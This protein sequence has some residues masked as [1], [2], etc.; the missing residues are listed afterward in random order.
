MMPPMQT[1]NLPKLNTNFS[2][3]WIVKNDKNSNSKVS[4]IDKNVAPQEPPSPSRSND[5][6]A[7]KDYD[8][9]ISKALRI[10]TPPN[11]N[12]QESADRLR[13]ASTS[14]K[15]PT[16]P[17]YENYA[18]LIGNPESHLIR[19][20][21]FLAGSGAGVNPK[22]NYFDKP[23]PQPHQS[24]NVPMQHPLTPPMDTAMQQQHSQILSAQI[25]MA[26]LNYQR[27]HASGHPQALNFPQIFS[28]NFHRTSYQLQPWLLN[29]RYPYGF[30]GG[31]HRLV[32]SIHLK[33]VQKQL[34]FILRFPNN[35][36]FI[37]EERCFENEN[38]RRQ[39][40]LPSVLLVC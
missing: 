15:T 36:F 28:N 8:Q 40:F 20:M 19:P 37:Y 23:L 5:P 11:S 32:R 12:D 13:T 33:F 16:M 10:Q 22:L 26:A 35:S 7:T 4:P 17:L 14:P 39:Y 38:C 2:I 31:K 18:R 1:T 30:S 24:A 27:H 34:I 25:Q 21:P 29:R 9:E 6:P 3:D